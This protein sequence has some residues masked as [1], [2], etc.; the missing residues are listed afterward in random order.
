MAGGLNS[1]I[2]EPMTAAQPRETSAE[3]GRLM[4]RA[5]YASVSVAAILIGLKFAAWLATGSVSMLAT[6]VDSMLDA[7]ASLVNLFAV[8]QALTPAD[9]EH[10]FGHG[11][12]EP[13][14]GLIQ[15]A[16]IAGSALFLLVEVA[17]RFVHPQAVEEG[18]LALVVMAVS[19]VMTLGL[20]TFQRYVVRKTASLAITADKLH[21][22]G[23][24]LA[25]ISVAV[26]LIL[27]TQFGLHLADPIFGAIIAVYIVW[28]AWEII[29]QSLD[30]LMDRELPDEERTRIRE[31]ALSHPEVRGVHD[32]RTR[33]S[34]RDKFIQL[35]IELERLATLARAHEVS[36]AVEAKLREAF[37][38][39]EVIIHQDPEGLDEPRATFR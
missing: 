14:A 27:A 18:G 32:L 22:L 23:D 29:R 25:N 1:F 13:L 10:R 9:R 2:R 21:Y 8:R 6:L 39:A 34:G 15:S 30:Q 19:V 36:A 35:H 24:M 28:S 7:V 38:G 31:I 17:R 3:H 12:A 37:P 33:A 5:T 11:K 16:F 4:R 20:V 26:A